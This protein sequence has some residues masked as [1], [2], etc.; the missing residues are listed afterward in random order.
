M[1]EDVIKVVAS[2]KNLTHIYITTFNI[3]FIFIENVLLRE[4]RKC[5]HPALTIFADANEVLSSFRSQGKWLS[6]IGRRYRVVPIRMDHGFR[7]HPKLIL[8]AGTEVADLFVGSGNLTFGGMRQND[9]FWVRFQTDQDGSGPLSAFREFGE[10]CLS[11]VPYSD[12][13]R[14]EIHGAF[15]P[16]Q[17]TWARSLE[18]PSGI[19]TKIGGGRPLIDLMIDTVGTLPLRRIVVGSPYFDE[20]GEA[21]VRIASQWPGAEISV[22]VQ[23]RQSQ[24]LAS[25]WANIREPKSLIPVTTSRNEGAQTFIHAKFY[26]FIGDTDAVLFVGSANCSA[27]ALL[28]PGASGNAE[29]LAVLRMKAS[30]VEAAFMSGL[31]V[32]AEPPVLT[33]EL[34][35]ASP[36]EA[37]PLV[38]IHTAHH[39]NGELVVAFTAPESSHSVHLVVDGCVLSASDVQLMR[40]SI[41]AR[42]V[43]VVNRVQVSVMVNGAPCVSPEHWVDHEFLLGASS[44]QRQLAQAISDHVTPG[45]WSFRGWTEVLRL[46]DNHLIYNSVGSEQDRDRVAADHLEDKEARHLR[47][48]DFFTDDYRLP[49]HHHQFIQ[50]DDNSKTLGLRGLLLDYFGVS[51]ERSSEE[52]FEVDD[53]DTVDVPEAVVTSSSAAKYSKAK[54]ELSDSERRRGQRIARKIVDACTSPEFIK[55]RPAQLLGADLSIIAVLLVSGKAENW[56]EDADFLD[57]TYRV[58]SFLFFDDGADETSVH[59]G[60]LVRRH[61]SLPS[62]REFEDALRSVRLAAS[63]ATW[64]FCCPEGIAHAEQARYELATRLAVGRLP[65]LWYLEARIQVEKELFEIA[66]RTGWLGTDAKNRWNEVF[67]RWDLLFAEGHALLVFEQA[68]RA[69]DIIDL[70]NRISDDDVAAGSLLWQGTRLGFCVLAESGKRVSQPKQSPRVLSLRSQRRDLSISAPFLLPFRSLVRVVGGLDPERF[71]PTLV[72]AL[73][74]LADRLEKT[75][76]RSN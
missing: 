66:Q 4:L 53:E 20:Q 50:L 17:H 44:R 25:A 72:E 12:T 52:S 43:G 41:R 15:E 75:V 60:A 48:A 24:L 56:L 1:R 22:M 39:E 58:W 45:Q 47:A 19:L 6:R 35:E 68:L 73:S 31:E 51:V 21:L 74:S 30:E 9:E 76:A 38:R 37:I 70:R 42:N 55:N 3:D 64:C 33:T 26:A 8:L 67:S 28:V 71:S 10:G 54:H 65:W 27:A 32:L 59:L 5:G 40:K 29:A 16:E 62:P 34:P 14:L 49:R 36:A 2:R 63:L 18:L 61:D 69:A 13:A 46:L 11:R 57:L 7:F 23:P